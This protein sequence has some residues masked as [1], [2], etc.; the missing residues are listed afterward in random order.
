MH[1]AAQW[2][3]CGGRKRCHLS[4]VRFCHRLPHPPHPRPTHPHPPPPAVQYI[5][6]D[7]IVSQLNIPKAHKLTPK[8]FAHSVHQICRS[9]LQNIV[10]PEVCAC[11]AF[12][13]RVSAVSCFFLLRVSPGV[14]S[15]HPPILPGL[16]APGRLFL[17]SFS[18]GSPC[19]H[20]QLADGGGT[21]TRHP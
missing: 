14:W 10:L 17:S 6:A 21:G 4:T 13:C 16:L 3:P 19:W 7:A 8:A 15:P 9:S 1:L 11:P 18:L 20:S 12:F 5:D 2:R